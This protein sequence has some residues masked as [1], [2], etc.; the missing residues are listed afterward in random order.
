M[1]IDPGVNN[2][3]TITDNLGNQPIIIKGGF[4][5]ARIQYFNKR[6]AEFLSKLTNGK[7][8]KTAS[9]AKKYTISKHSIK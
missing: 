1:G 4:I 5:K 3:A 6:R 8:R 7:D 9:T 2:F